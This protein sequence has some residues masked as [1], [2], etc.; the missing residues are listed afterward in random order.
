MGY[1][2]KILADSI[3]PAGHRLTT[4]EVTFPRIVLAE[5]NTHRMLSRNSA[6]SRAIPAA[7]MI[8][9]VKEDPF[10]P[11]YWGKNQKGMQANQELD[12]VAR[13]FARRAWGESKEKAVSVVKYLIEELDLHKQIANRLLEPWLWHTVI[14]SAT[15]WGNLF[16][17]R[18]NIKAQPEIRAVAHL[19]RELYKREDDILLRRNGDVGA[20]HLPLVSFEE[21][22]IA[23]QPE[24]SEGYV[25]T[26]DLIKVSVARCARVSYLTHDGRRDLGEDLRLY[27]DLLTAGHMSPFEHAA[28][29]MTNEELDR[30]KQAHVEWRDDHWFVRGID[31]FLGNFNGWVQLRKL[32]PGEADILAARAEVQS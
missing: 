29:P 23:T 7:K 15:E 28:R 18:D 20:W 3:S 8:A 30:F 24:L 2:V 27:N 6:S 22:L 9:R 11:V 26:E 19:M 13:G 25:S 17:L 5:F 14:V 16:N 10:V 32:I 1:A 4:F 12:E 31:H 21:R